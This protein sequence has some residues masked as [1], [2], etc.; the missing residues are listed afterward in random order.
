MGSNW[1]IVTRRWW[2][3]YG[4]MPTM[5][6]GTRKGWA[7]SV[8]SGVVTSPTSRRRGENGDG[9]LVTEPLNVKLD[10]IDDNGNPRTIDLVAHYLGS[11]PFDPGDAILAAIA[12]QILGSINFVLNPE[13]PSQHVHESEGGTDA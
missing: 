11:F 6:D 3:V 1:K 10:V 4:G 2:H 8:S 13:V 7:H 12:D 9:K 5:P